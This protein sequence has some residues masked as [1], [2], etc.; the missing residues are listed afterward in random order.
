VDVVVFDKTGTLTLG[1]PQIVG[2]T[3]Y[4]SATQKEILGLAAAAER[5]SE[6]PLAKAILTKADQEH[7]DVILV[8]DWNYT[9]GKQINMAA[10]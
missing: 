6:H 8:K 7:A 5:S 3:V 2:V 10:C 4:G 1:E 9:P